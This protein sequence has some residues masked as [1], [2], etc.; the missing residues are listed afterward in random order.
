MPSDSKQFILHSPVN[1]LSYQQA[2]NTV[3]DSLQEGVRINVVTPYATFWRYAATDDAF[4]QAWHSADLALPDGIAVLWAHRMCS[5]R[6]SGNLLVRFIQVI[7]YA[8]FN[9][10]LILAGKLEI[11]GEFE[12]VPGADLVPDLLRYAEEN[13][14]SV[15]ILG[16]WK[17]VLDSFTAEMNTHYPSLCYQIDEQVAETDVRTEAGK[18]ILA[19]AIGRVQEFKPD[20]LIVSFGPP[21]QEKWSRKHFDQLHASVV[22]NAGA[23]IDF[24]SGRMQRAPK[25]LRKIGLEWVWRLITQ[26]KRLRRI[27]YAFPYFPFKVVTYLITSPQSGIDAV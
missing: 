20:L 8:V 17:E 7:S 13:N 6:L 1:F 21:F 25:L 10:G 24:L 11:K 12:R 22:I 2:L 9:F 18:G 27:F 26:P 19:Q 3:S 5:Y 16:G 4:R 15:Y 23:T 14:K